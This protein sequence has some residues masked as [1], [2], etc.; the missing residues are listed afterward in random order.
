MRESIPSDM[1]AKRRLKSACAFTQSCYPKSTQRRFRSDCAY[2][3][4]D[5][6]LRCLAIQK[7]TQ[8]RFRS[9]CAYAQTGLNLRCVHM[10]EGT[11]L[12][13][14]YLLF[15][16][17]IKRPSRKCQYQGD[18]EWALQPHIYHL[19]LPR[20]CKFVI[21]WV[22]IMPFDEKCNIL[23]CVG[24]TLQFQWRFHCHFL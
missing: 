16:Q 20:Y 19:L 10:S 18:S 13:L 23:V 9:D 12:R 15:F 11:A 6:N 3:Q 21:P 2:A 5:L 7:S 1:C 4:S 22:L 14:I 17:S 8:R 24:F